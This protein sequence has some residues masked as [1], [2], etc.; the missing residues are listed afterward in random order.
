MEDTSDLEIDQVALKYS[1][2]LSENANRHFAGIIP[3]QSTKTD[4]HTHAFRAIYAHIATLYYCPVHLNELVYVN[5]ILGHFQ[6]K[7]DQHRRDYA[8]TTRYFDYCIGLDGQ[9]DGRQGILLS[10]QRPVLEVFRQKG[11][12]AMNSKTASTKEVEGLVVK[13]KKSRGLLTVSQ[14]TADMVADLMSKRGMR[15]QDEIV[16]DLVT[17]DGLYH[18]LEALLAPLAESMQT[19][20]PIATLEALLAGQKAGSAVEGMSELLQEVGQEKEPVQYLRGLVSRDRHF[21]TALANRHSGTDYSILSLEQLSKIKTPDASTERFKRAVDAIMAHNQ[22]QTDPLHL[23]YI[24]SAVVRELVGGR[25]EAVQLYLET[26][27][28]EIEEHHKQFSLTSKQNRK[29]ISIADQ[30]KVM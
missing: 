18:Q 19:E 5:T 4:L 3:Q 28:E 2:V 7:D 15:K 13:E 14:S 26:R 10:D 1:K 30:I 12:Q 17:N 16:S 29:P 24:Q 21:K 11:N 6:A 20:G 9:I 8:A 27:K 22:A 23:W 25:N